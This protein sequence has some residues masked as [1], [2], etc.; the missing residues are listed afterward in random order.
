MFIQ[1]RPESDGIGGD[2]FADWKNRFHQSNIPNEVNLL[3]LLSFRL[4]KIRQDLG[5]VQD[6]FGFSS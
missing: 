2:A 5:E 1:S 6:R 4:K 3:T